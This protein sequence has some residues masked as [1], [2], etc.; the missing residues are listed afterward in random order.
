[1]KKLLA[2]ILA[3]PL[4]AMNLCLFVVPSAVVYAQAP[5][6]ANKTAICEGI[7]FTGGNCDA[8]QGTTSVNNIVKEVIRILS[9]VVGVVSVIM[10][11]IGGFKYITS[12]GDPAGVNG[13]KNTILYA[14]VGLV[15]VAFAQIIVNFV[16]NRAVATP[17]CSPTV[18]TNCTP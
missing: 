8:A 11:I 9:I 12:T 15:I 1:M 7:G 3:S 18:T 17:K 4:I 2:S 16:L 6:D 13:A 14:I 10:I 5:T